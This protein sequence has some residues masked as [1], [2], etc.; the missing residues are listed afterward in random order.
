[1]TDRTPVPLMYDYALPT[2]MS[3]MTAA[4]D[5]VPASQPTSMLTVTAALPRALPSTAALPTCYLMSTIVDRT[6]AMNNF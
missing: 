6:L 4:T 3:D 1:V 5:Y 2:L